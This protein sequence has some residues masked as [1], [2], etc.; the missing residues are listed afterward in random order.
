MGEAVEVPDL[1][2]RRGGP[3]FDLVVSKLRP[4]RRR[5]AAVPREIVERLTLA[6]MR[7][8][9]S[10]VA[11]AGF[12]KTNLLAELGEQAARARHGFAWVSVDERDNDPRVMLAYVA[13]ALDRIQPVGERVFDALASSATSVSGSVVP[14]LA[15]AFA[16]MTSPVMLVLDDVH[17]LHNRECRSAL[18]VLAEH[19]PAKSALVLAGRDAP[20]LR[21][22]RLRAEGRITEVGPAELSMTLAEATLLFKAAGLSLDPADVTVLHERTEGWPVGL[23][24]AALYLREGG[25]VVAAAASFGGDDR[26]VSDYLESEL[27][28]RISGSHRAFLTRSAALTSM[29]AA[30]CEAVLDLPDAAATLADLAGS[31]LLLVPLDRRGQWYRY[32]T[33][34]GEMLW[35]QLERLEPGLAVV[36]RRRAASW[37]LSHQRPEDA[38]EYSMAA[39]DV[40]AVVDLFR[41]LWRPVWWQGR[42]STL[43]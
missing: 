1:V 37:C 33:L 17:L 12:G 15:S 31:N 24:L 3:T 7:P 14:R 4:P 25:S 35:A 34:F 38:M 42:F 21:V 29:S 23:Y 5:G 13:T 28:E 11:P 40:D 26:L 16:A 27:L 2:L 9:V 39:G 36:L 20:P 10:V 19:V 6:Q 22:A 8:V 41:E 43:R 18:S 32:H 30:L